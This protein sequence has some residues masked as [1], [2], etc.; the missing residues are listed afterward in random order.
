V[1]EPRHSPCIYVLAGTNGAG[2]SSLAGAAFLESGVEFFNPDQ[3]ALQIQSANP[4]ITAAQANSA[5]WHQ[6]KRLLQRAVAERLNFAFETTLGGETITTVLIAALNKKLEVRIW[7]VG[8]LNVNLHIRRVRS[9]VARGG[10]DIPESRIRSRYDSSRLNL[11]RLLP[12]LAELRLYDNSMDA[13]PNAGKT[14]KPALLLHLVRG[15]IETS[16]NLTRTPDW[17]K[18][19]MAAAMKL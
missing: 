12:R 5:A 6:G 7:Y 16:C 8:L 2:K 10:H 4:G 3:A 11:I 17:A 18:P 19:I 13:D 9:R 14:P 1:A 15:R